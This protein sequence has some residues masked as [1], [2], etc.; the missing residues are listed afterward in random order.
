MIRFG[1]IIGVIGLILGNI[2]P[3]S[4]DPTT[5]KPF[6]TFEQEY[7]DNILFTSN[8]EEEDFI[9]T[10]SGGLDI[11]QKTET[12]NAG[13]YARLDQLLYWEFDELNF[14]NKYFYGDLKYRQTER[15]N[16]GATAG[17][18]EDSRRDRDADTTGLLVTGD[19]EITYVSL[20]SDYHFTETTR[21]EMALGYKWIT[22]DDIFKTEDDDDFSVDISF[23]TNLNQY[24]K[25]TTGILNLSYL[26]YVADIESHVNGP[27]QS[28][29]VF[30]ENDSDIFQFSTGFSKDITEIYNVYCLA[31]ASYTQTNE[32]GS[33]QRRVTGTDIIISDATIPEAEDDN[34]GGV[35]SAGLKYDMGLS[36]SQDMRGASGANGT[37]QRTA[38]AGN[39][40]GRV[41]DKFS[42]T[43]NASCYL[44]Q[45]ETINQPDTDDF[46][47]N[48]QP[49]FRYKFVRDFFLSGYYRFTS[50][51]NRQDDTF[52]QRNLIYFAI[53]KEFE[54]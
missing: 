20:L 30:Q 34:W 17:Y 41:T 18:S 35:L 50:V 10:I 7:S 45:N 11:R 32:G 6:L 12:L 21:G 28:S 40:Y 49:G 46:T 31:G 42:L 53:T 38:L 52:R 4:A 5:I 8:F 36:L 9:S 16:I 25:N 27:T 1:F 51:E 19:R 3:A 33:I 37:V 2:F 44:N 14:L 47:A 15:L 24:F 48:I 39:I 54:L 26:R 22:I 43:L 29:T 13:L 23:L